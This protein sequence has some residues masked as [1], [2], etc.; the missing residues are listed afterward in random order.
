MERPSDPPRP[1]TLLIAATIFYGLMSAA[2]IIVLALSD[3]D[4]GLIVFGPS[5]EDVA[6]GRAPPALSHPLAAL[7]GAAAGGVVVVLSLVFRKLG[8]IDRLH[9]EF[10]SVLGELSTGT[11]AV[12][13][14][15]S[16]VGEELLFR[17]ALQPLIGFWPTAA[18][19]GLLHGGGAPRLF[20]WTLFAFLSGL[21]LGWLADFTGS[22]L[23]PIL[24]H[25]TINFWN[26]QAITERPREGAP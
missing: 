20:A 6:T 14:V 16:A 2:A 1:A 26:L 23:A 18:L 8:P 13:A 17:G 22:L 15:T 21:L 4:P 11:V 19:F 9:K 12:L 24:C 25:L 5:L 7:L 3:L 10:S